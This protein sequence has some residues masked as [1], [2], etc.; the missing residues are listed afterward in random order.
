MVGWWL[1]NIK[2]S[3]SA[4]KPQATKPQIRSRC[5][6]S[7]PHLNTGRQPPGRNPNLSSCHLAAAVSTALLSCIPHHPATPSLVHD[8]HLPLS[9]AVQVAMRRSPRIASP[10]PPPR[11]IGEPSHHSILPLHALP[12]RSSLPKQH[13]SRAPADCGHGSARRS[14][15]LITPGT[16]K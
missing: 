7:T 13:A 16:W 15:S 2:C 3:E 12:H 11:P 10:P 1:L 4:K 6:H 5:P 8:P 9:L 14:I